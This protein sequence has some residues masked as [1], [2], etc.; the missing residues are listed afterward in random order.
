MVHRKRHIAVAIAFFWIISAALSINAQKG[1]ARY[2][3]SPLHV[4]AQSETAVIGFTPAQIRKAYGF[5]QL[6]N[7]GA[8]Q[9]IAIVVPFDDDR[10]EEDLNTFS[11]TFGLPECTTLNGCFRKIFATDK[12][13]ATKAIWT[14]E[15][16]LAV[17]WAHAIAP[18]AH[19]LLVEAPSDNLDDMLAAVDVAVGNGATVVSMS[20]GV[21]E[22]SGETSNDNHFAAIAT[23][24]T[25]VAASGNFGNG[26]FYPAASPNVVGVG[27]TTL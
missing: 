19:I 10:I 12:N 6:T 16:A 18:D 25:F 3:R 20:W 7:R 24:V 11:A 17:E 15:A 2:V 9:T 22:F 4:Q 27:G 1:G 8:G 14:L 26:A 23:G 5:D 13:P 21:P